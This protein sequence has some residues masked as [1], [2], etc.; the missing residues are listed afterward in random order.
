MEG[1]ELDQAGD[2]DK[3]FQQAA[4]QWFHSH[5]QQL[6]AIAEEPQQPAW[7]AEWDASLAD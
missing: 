1:M 2:F 5:Q 6:E 7:K 3:T 4:P